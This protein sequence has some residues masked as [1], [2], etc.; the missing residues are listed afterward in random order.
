MLFVDISTWV[1]SMAWPGLAALRRRWRHLLRH[2]RVVAGDKTSVVIRTE[3][4]TRPRWAGS[5]RCGKVPPCSWSH[6]RVTFANA[7]FDGA[8]AILLSA[9]TAI[10]AHPIRAA[11]AAPSSCASGRSWRSFAVSALDRGVPTIVATQMLESMTKSP[12]PTR[13][14]PGARGR[15]LRSGRTMS[16]WLPLSLRP[17]PR[18]RPARRPPRG[19]RRTGDARW[20]ASGRRVAF[21][22]DAEI[23]RRLAARP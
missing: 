10:G 23:P 20:L 3:R 14:G 11:E 8:D 4:M 18:S 5:P 21:V 16:R 15:R 6:R 9:E 1:T 12:Y 19:R 17:R 2:R 7:V 13:G 22:E